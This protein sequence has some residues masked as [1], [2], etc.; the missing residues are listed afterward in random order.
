MRSTRK[1]MHNLRR[2]TEYA[3]QNTTL[4]VEHMLAVRMQSVSGKRSNDDDDDDS[5]G[6]TDRG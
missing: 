1:Y 4:H 5:G 6:K 2:Y 3:Q